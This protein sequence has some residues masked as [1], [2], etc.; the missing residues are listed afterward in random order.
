[1]KW[2]CLEA[3]LSPPESSQVNNE[4][5]FTISEFTA[6]QRSIVYSFDAFVYLYEGM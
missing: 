2:P 6:H 4:R 5:G 3:G 1:M